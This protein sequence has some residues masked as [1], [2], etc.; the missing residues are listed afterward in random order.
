[1]T[2]PVDIDKHLVSSGREIISDKKAVQNFVKAE[3]SNKLLLR[4]TAKEI[5]FEKVDFK[6]TI[7]DTCYFRSCSFDSCDFTGCRFVG[8]NFHG[9]SF[10]GCKF[11]YSNFERTH[12]DAEVFDNAPAYENLKQRFARA[13][14]MNFQSIG[15]ATLVNKAIILELEAEKEHL[16]KSCR[17]TESYYRKKYSGI[18]RIRQYFLW[19]YFRLLDFVWG[20]GESLPKFLRTLGLIW[21]VIFVIDISLLRDISEVSDYLDSFIAIPGIFLGNVKPDYYSDGYLSAISITRFISIGL[22]VSL[23]IKRFNRR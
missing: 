14:R 22:F 11:D 3:L 18:K 12:I 16:K 4:F 9:S 21:F 5:K 7:F 10:I 15:D 23:I 8:S 1:M 17:S 19:W 20:N 2:N 6:Y 13:L